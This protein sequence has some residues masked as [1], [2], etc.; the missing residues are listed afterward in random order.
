MIARVWRGL[1]RESDKDTED[2]EMLD[3][4]FSICS[5]GAM[6]AERLALCVLCLAT[7]SLTAHPSHFRVQTANASSP[8]SPPSAPVRPVTD[9]YYGT[10]VTDPYRYMENL[11]D[12][13]VQSWMKGQND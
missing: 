10:K 11:A 6:R 7:I 1:T 5:G 2:N 8:P 4:C 12:P 3:L 13:E 9:I